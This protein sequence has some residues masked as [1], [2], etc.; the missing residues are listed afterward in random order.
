LRIKD[1]NNVVWLYEMLK[2]LW[3]GYT[4]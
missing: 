4:I 2:I 3:N 1:E